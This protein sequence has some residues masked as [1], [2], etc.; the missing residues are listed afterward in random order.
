MSAG[1]MRTALALS[2]GAA[3]SLGL[4]RFSYA[5]LLPPMRA[6]LQ[7]SYFTAGAMNTANAAGYL[8]GALMAPRWLAR[9]DARR[10]FL[11]GMGATAVLLALHAAASGDALIAALRFATGTASAATFVC[12]GLLAARLVATSARAGAQ[13][14]SHSAGLVLGL[15]YG[16]T[17]AGIVASALIVPAASWAVS[18]F[19]WRAAWLGLGIA[20]FVAAW[21]SA[22][23]TGKMASPPSVRGAQGSF[24]WRTLRYGLVAYLMFGLG[25]IGYMTFVVT[26]LRERGL[27]AATVTAFYATLGIA[28]MA[29]PW[30]WARLLE[31]HRGGVP[32]AL[33]NALLSVA[34]VLPA[35]GTEPVLVFISGAL[36]GAVFLSIVA[37]TTA[38]VRHNVSAQAWSRGIAA[39]T[40]V[41]AIGQI[42]GPSVVGLIADGGGGLR[43]GFVVSACLLALGSIVGWMQRPVVAAKLEA[44]PGPTG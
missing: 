34:T 18:G 15:Y 35:W 26:L 37:S 36:F 16:G 4:A 12:G 43:A 11:W 14:A 19:A 21:V 17:G 33:L 8:A 2:L 31:R 44:K 30:L 6:D 38:M 5:L 10:V 24:D 20:A 3:V 42:V 22:R 32:I 29:S 7:W 40:I 28:V 13:A 1:T 27:D 9:H 25:Y 41:F 23:G 39:F